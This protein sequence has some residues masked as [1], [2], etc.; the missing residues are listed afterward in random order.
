MF[1][2]CQKCPKHHPTIQ[3]DFD[4]IW[5]FKTR[6][7]DISTISELQEFMDKPHRKVSDVESFWFF[8]VG[9]SDVRANVR[10]WRPSEFLQLNA[11]GELGWIWGGL[12][13]SRTTARTM[14]ISSIVISQDLVL[15]NIRSNICFWHSDATLWYIC[16]GSQFI[17]LP[18]LHNIGPICWHSPVIK[19]AIGESIA[20]NLLRNEFYFSVITYIFCW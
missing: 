8:C 3:T 6:K 14:R 7:L 19:A 9:P 5:L 16:N 20:L 10:S 13:I 4:T 1:R 17:L 18:P 15:P 2:V 12:E 11:Q